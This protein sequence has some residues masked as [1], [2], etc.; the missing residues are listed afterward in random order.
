MADGASHLTPIAI[1]GR[2]EHD[3]MSGRVASPGGMRIEVDELVEIYARA[4]G[5][6]DPLADTS[7]A[8][9]KG[10]TGATKAGSTAGAGH[11]SSAASDDEDD[12]APRRPTLA[13]GMPP[14]GNGYRDRSPSTR[15]TRSAIRMMKA[16][17]ASS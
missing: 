2:V 8:I 12:G 6:A 16:P 14:N 4:H 5:L 10:A 3:L 17:A 15:R 13:A 9:A 7:Q 1:E 11:A